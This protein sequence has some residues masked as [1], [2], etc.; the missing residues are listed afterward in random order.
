MATEALKSTSVTALDATPIA[1][2]TAGAGAPS[3]LWH[4]G[5]YIACSASMDVG[6]TYRMLRL[7]SN[8]KLKD[9][10]FE[11]A[12]LGAGAFDIG[13][14]YSDSAND[15]TPAASQGLVIDADFFASAVNCA[16]A[17]ARASYFNES[18]N[19]L[20][21]KRNQPLWQALGISADPGGFIDIV[22]T[23]TTAIT[24]GGLVAVSAEYTF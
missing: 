24:T 4:L 9:L 22:L 18:G 3:Y 6:S 19:N 11:A 16:S 13:A 20:L 1:Q 15:G 23:V 21:S 17:V 8:A 7:P 14:Y 12:A 10:V 2:V 5:E